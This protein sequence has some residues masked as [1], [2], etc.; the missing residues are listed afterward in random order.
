MK[1]DWHLQ[2][3]LPCVRLKSLF[4]QE[5][6]AQRLQKQRATTRLA[7]RKPKK[8]GKLYPS[9]LQ[10][11]HPETIGGSTGK[12][13]MRTQGAATSHPKQLFYQ[14]VRTLACAHTMDG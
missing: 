6:H 13:C 5:P 4:I 9:S 11:A 8:K 2:M 7:Y 10:N 1:L 12:G 3:L 14:A